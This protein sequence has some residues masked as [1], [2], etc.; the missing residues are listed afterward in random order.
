MSEY[1]YYEFQAIDRPLSRDEMAEL[2]RLSTR[3]TITPTSFT[4]FYTF[5]DFKG[6]PLALMERYFDAF[7]YVANWGSRR[8][9]LRLPQ[10]LL[11]LSRISLYEAEGGL[12]L[13]WFGD[14]VILDFNADAEE[15]DWETAGEG[16]LAALVPLRADIA[17]G[18]LRAL[19]LSW[20]SA[21]RCGLVD[22]EAL[23][24]PVPPGLGSL[25]AGLA[26]LAEFLYVDED[27]LAVAAAV[28]GPL[29]PA[30]PP[31]DEVAA[32]IG[33]LPEAEKN[34]LLVRLLEG[35]PTHVQAEL[36]R[37]YRE[38]QARTAAPTPV[39]E[40]GGRTAAALLEA[41][42]E[43]AEARRREEA[44]REAAER[45]RR[46]REEAVARAAYLDGLVGQDERLWSQVER[47]VEIRQPD[48]YDQAVQLLRDLHD[49]AA[50]AGTAAAFESRLS[51]L[52]A[53][54]ARKST[55]VDRLGRAGLA[56]R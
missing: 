7:V 47:L 4:N 34:T 26:A 15:P 48:S 11:D 51:D 16:W 36:L 53:R 35:S 3:A 12:T 14:Q 24:P 50:R 9:M 40:A 13:H 8:L 28:S 43:R 19:Y 41:A 38:A 23:E 45:A 32:W 5:G 18:D 20:L 33:A 52:R 22:E 17:A 39:A 21:V 25:S 10:T 2:R 31:T 27:L 29:P 56:A 49:L 54:H 44:A 30:R 6:D 1:Q 55:F 46:A 42:E 37:R